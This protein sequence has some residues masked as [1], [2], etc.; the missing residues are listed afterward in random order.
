MQVQLVPL[1][2]YL[3]LTMGAM[4][5]QH[6]LEVCFLYQVAQVVNQARALLSLLSDKAQRTTPPQLQVPTS[7]PIL[8][9]T[10]NAQF[11]QELQGLQEG[12]LAGG[13]VRNTEKEQEPFLVKE[14]D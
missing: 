12:F 13:Q 10:V 9:T 6:H 8:E 7:F 5:G 1:A 2:E 11:L 14:M 4:A 3:V